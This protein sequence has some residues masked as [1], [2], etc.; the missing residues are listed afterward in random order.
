MYTVASEIA[1]L[2]TLLLV[3]CWE[4]LEVHF[5]VIQFFGTPNAMQVG[6][7][8]AVLEL[9]AFGEKEHFRAV[10]QILHTS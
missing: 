5:R 10:S 4:S 2:T 7:M 8:V 6:T 3:L 9:S 1:L